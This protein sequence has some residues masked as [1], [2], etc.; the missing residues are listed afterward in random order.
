[1]Y[2]NHVKYMMH[3]LLKR[4]SQRIR[5]GNQRKA[6]ILKQFAI[7]GD[8]KPVLTY[9][10]TVTSWHDAFGSVNSVNILSENPYP[11]PRNSVL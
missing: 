1:M 10:V 8:V 7:Y 9:V 2:F 6:L 3:P 11:R 4:H 5:T